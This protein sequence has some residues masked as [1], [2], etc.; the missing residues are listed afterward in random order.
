VEAMRWYGKAAEQGHL[1]AIQHLAMMNAM[2][3]ND[4][5]AV[6]WFRKGAE[7]G[8]GDCMWGLGQCYLDGRGE[9]QDTILAYALFSASLDGVENPQQKQAMTSRRDTFGKALTAEQL[10]KTEPLIQEW[11]AKYRK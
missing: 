11:I 10:K 9:K 7:M 1:E 6:K 8:S 5:E 2:S 4:A 3:K